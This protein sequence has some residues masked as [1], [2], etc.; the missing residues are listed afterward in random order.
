VKKNPKGEDETPFH[1][2]ARDQVPLYAPS[3]RKERERWTER[4]RGGTRISAVAA[5][6]PP[7][8]AH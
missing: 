4:E 6:V 1:P 2:H 5:A 7:R 8:C 3:T